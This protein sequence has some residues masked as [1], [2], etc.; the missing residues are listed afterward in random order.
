MRTRISLRLVIYF[1]IGVIS[2]IAVAE[3]AS[4]ADLLHWVSE[5]GSNL[6]NGYFLQTKFDYKAKAYQIYAKH[7]L[8]NL[9]A[10]TTRFTGDVELKQNGQIVN[11][12]QADVILDKK[13]N[14]LAEVDL[15]GNI[16]FAEKDQL[17][18]GDK[19]HI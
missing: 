12:D 1:G 7:W 3:T 13:D 8:H 11:A 15:S 5:A 2:T 4:I 14:S 16:R 10:R 6:C 18:V 17:L 19:A 9:N